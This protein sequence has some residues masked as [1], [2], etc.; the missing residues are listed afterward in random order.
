VTQF[1]RMLITM[2]YLHHIY[3]GRC[4]HFLARREQAPERTILLFGV[5]SAG[6]RGSGTGRGLMVTRPDVARRFIQGWTQR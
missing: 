5:R 4:G 1:T 2:D 6:S 3:A